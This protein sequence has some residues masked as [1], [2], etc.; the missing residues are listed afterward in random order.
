M[1]KILF[2][3][4]CFV[5]AS[6]TPF[7]YCQ[8]YQTKP[9]SDIQVKDN[10]LVYEDDNCVIYYDF[11]KNYGEMGFVF[12]N[13]TSENIS[14]HL[15]ECFYVRNGYAFD[16]YKNR[17]STDN[18]VLLTSLSQSKP[19]VSTKPSSVASGIPFYTVDGLSTILNAHGSGSLN[20]NGY[21]DY[22]NALTALAPT[23]ILVYEKPIVVIP[24]KAGK[25]IRE[26]NIKDAVYRSC[27]LLLDYGNKESQSLSFTKDNTPLTFGNR[28]AYTIGDSKDLIRINNDFYV[29][30]ITNYRMST[31]T[32]LAKD[33]PCGIKQMN[34]IRVV[35]ESG[36]DKF[37][38]LRT[39]YTLEE[40]LLLK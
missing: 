5:M 25:I 19:T 28:I 6:C 20:E 1:K 18:I 8:M 26:F 32:E 30:K 38:I 39:D 22:A 34:G 9:I 24:P 16:Y 2:V 23:S 10:T 13:K 36:P 33:V 11:W 17:I 21:V 12:Y 3:L 31:I 27:D 7:Q 35:K 37:F 14:L 40:P 29:S 15:D 4:V